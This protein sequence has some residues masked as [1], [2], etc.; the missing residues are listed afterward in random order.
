MTG[1]HDGDE[2]EDDGEAKK[3]FDGIA[4]FSNTLLSLLTTSFSFLTLLS[5]PHPASVSMLGVSS[6]FP[7]Q[8]AFLACLPSGSW[9][10]FL[11]SIL[12]C[13]HFYSS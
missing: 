2:D 6:Y 10:S 9:L 3:E 5:L 8:S 1:S 4:D 11:A 7:L 12:S 13:L